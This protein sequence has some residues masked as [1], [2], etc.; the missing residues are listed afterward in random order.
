MSTSRR[1]V[2]GATPN[3]SYRHGFEWIEMYIGPGETTIGHGSAPVDKSVVHMMPQ[4]HF[5]TYS[6]LD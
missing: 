1:T 2:S 3:R 5:V 6:F 4:V